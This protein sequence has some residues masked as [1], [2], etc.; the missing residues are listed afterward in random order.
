[1]TTDR[2]HPDHDART[3]QKVDK[4][5]PKMPLS[6][7]LERRF[8]R[9][10]KANCRCATGA[11]HGPY[12]RHV[13][14]SRGERRRRYVPLAAVEVTCTALATWRAQR[15]A[16]RAERRAIRA[17]RGELAAMRRLLAALS[18]EQEQ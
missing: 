17:L 12:A 15:H 6:G 7:N 1:V 10:G 3:D 11:L 4:P 2:Q 5:A 14:W 16:V 8:V 18:A 9:C 13:T